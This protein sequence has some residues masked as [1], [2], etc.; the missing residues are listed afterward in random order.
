MNQSLRVLFASERPPYPFFLGGA[1]RCAHRLLQSM[2]GTSQA[3]CC[4]VGSAE[5]SGSPW[6]YPQAQDRA[7][8]GV[9]GIVSPS[10]GP[11]ANA[12]FAGPTIDCGYPVGVMRNFFNALGRLI[13]D[14]KPDLVW[15][16]LDGAQE[17]LSVASHKG[18]QGLLYVHDAE[19]DHAELR[20]TTSLGCHI[21]CSSEF[22]ARKARK[23]IG[24]P[25]HVVYPASDWFFGTQSDPSGHVTMINPHK[26]KG[27]D[28]FL[29]IARGL[30]DQTF[31][32][33]ESWKLSEDALGALHSRLSQLPNVRFQHRVSDMREIYRQTRLL[34][35]PSVW[36]EGFGMVAVE[37]QSCG[38]PV[39]A[40]ARGGLPESV[41][42]GGILIQDYLNVQAWLDAMHSI[43]DEEANYRVWSARALQHARSP[44][45]DP[46]EL[47]RRFLAICASPLPGAGSSSNGW[48]S[49]LSGLARL[50]LV[51]RIIR[52]ARR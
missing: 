5:Y 16:Q 32:L 43:L 7:A 27:I 51:G 21:V 49:L 10:P 30:P 33:V 34:L 28:T 6:T 8:L 37:A 36:E 14:F 13:D 26:V 52:E 11:E 22:L 29:E 18:V 45:F 40:S 47:A 23:I 35:V 39:I 31:L 20:A 50:P 12:E 2:S 42:D 19:F 44:D 41:G 17:I 46:D 15:A 25:A 48:H 9:R 3:E 38:I 24:R 4:A 1:A